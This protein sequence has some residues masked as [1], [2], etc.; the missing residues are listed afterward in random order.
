MFEKAII[1]ACS[2]CVDT[3]IFIPHALK[4][5]EEFFKESGGV[6]SNFCPKCIIKDADSLRF[7]LHQIAVLQ[8]YGER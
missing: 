3:G 5:A 4:Q 8:L 2:E 7:S 1:W 6:Y